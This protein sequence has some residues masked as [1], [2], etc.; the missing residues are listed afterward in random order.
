MLKKDD[1]ILVRIGLVIQL[2]K[3]I[4]YVLKINVKMNKCYGL[5]KINCLSW[6]FKAGLT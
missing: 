4:F 6:P 1:E 5:L 3:S 2:E